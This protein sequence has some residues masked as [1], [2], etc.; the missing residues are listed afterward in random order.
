MLGL[1]GTSRLVALMVLFGLALIVLVCVILLS[2]QP[3]SA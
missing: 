1:R 2:T 3:V